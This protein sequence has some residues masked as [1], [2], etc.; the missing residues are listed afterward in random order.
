MTT[1]KQDCERL[2][3][4]MLPLAKQMLVTHG[5]FYPYG[6]MMR[7]DGS[8]IHIGAQESGNE[9]PASSALVEMLRGHF[10]EQ[11]TTHAIIASCLI[12]DV[13]IARPGGNTKTDAIQV[14]L[15]HRADYSVE[16]VFPYRLE[17]EKVVLDVPFAQAGTAQV[18]T[19]PSA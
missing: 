14:N 2:M 8:I 18:F 9:H 5:E 7:T 4:E 6:G 15:D 13:L 12:F 17:G 16:V 3:D 19:K 10:H 11:A 1:P